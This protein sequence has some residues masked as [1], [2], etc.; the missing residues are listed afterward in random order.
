MQPMDVAAVKL[1]V[2]NRNGAEPVDV[3]LRDLTIR[4]DRINGLGTI[5]RTVFD[6]VVYADP[7]VD[8]EGHPDRRRPAQDAARAARRTP[9]RPRRRPARSPARRRPAAAAGAAAAAVAAP[10]AVV[11]APAPAPAVVVAVARPAASGVRAGGRCRPRSRPRTPTPPAGGRAPADAAAEPAAEA[12]GQD[13]ARRSREHPLRA[14]ARLTARFMGQPNLDFTMPG[15]SYKPEAKKHDL[16]EDVFAPDPKDPKNLA[17]QKAAEKKAEPRKE[18]SEESR[19]PRRPTRR[20]PRSRTTSSPRRRARR[21]TKIPKVEPKKN[22]IRDLY[23]SLFSLRPSP[24]KQVT[25]NCQTDKGPTSWRLDTSD[26]E[27]W[28]LVVR[29]RGPSR[30]PTSSSSRRPATAFR[31]TSRSRHVRG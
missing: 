25:V 10:A 18:R 24:I 1:F 20:R 8:R 30:R 29:R 12:Q 7:T 14:V 26:S 27:D 23:L 5:V 21:S 6:E 3:L 9:S 28:P 16:P 22:G 11:A 19:P 2:T 4:A 13:P 15:R 31:R 17:D